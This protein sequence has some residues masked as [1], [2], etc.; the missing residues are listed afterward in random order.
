MNDSNLSIYDILLV[1]LALLTPF[2][3][4]GSLLGQ[5]ITLS[6]ADLLV[7]LV[8]LLFLIGLVGNWTLPSL[9]VPI[10]AFLLVALVSIFVVYL[11]L[12]ETSVNFVSG[13]IGIG[14]MAGSVAWFFALYVL[15]ADDPYRRIWVFSVGSISTSTVL[16]LYAFLHGF[17]G[18]AY[19]PTATFGNPNLFGVYLLL[20]T[21]LVFVLIDLYM[22][23][24]NR[25]QQYLLGAV[26]MPILLLGVV[27]TGSRAAFGSL[28][29]LLV[30]SFLHYLSGSRFERRRQW[31][32]IG[33]LAIVGLGAILLM[34]SDLLLGSR[35]R[36]LLQGKRFGRRFSMWAT[37]LRLFIDHPIIGIGFNQWQFNPMTRE[38]F[39]E[40]H[41]SYIQ[42]ASEL[43]LLGILA[44][45]WLVSTLY[46]NGYQLISHPGV[47]HLIGFI[48]AI[49]AFGLFHNIENFRSL[50][51]GI[52]F[53]SGINVAQ[54]ER[55]TDRKP[56]S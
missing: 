30:F 35:F 21:A 25:W 23:N 20:N 22:A 34:S 15:I 10:F 38:L 5:N 42:I 17:F 14:K 4:K 8:L 27:I 31:I 6:I 3:F 26:A 37:A 45:G 47:P 43:G 49:F 1:L 13:M 24:G 11:T 50:W 18:G 28:L 40:A 12:P 41:N 56:T 36:S 48:T 52:A 54:Y 51:I 39:G 19:R 55:S 2:H 29:I 44:F 7:F 9:S 53:L 16:A 46:R 32:I 33:G